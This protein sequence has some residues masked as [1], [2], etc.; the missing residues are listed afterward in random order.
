MGYQLY[1]EPKIDEKGNVENQ[2]AQYQPD[3]RTK[4]RLASLR[5]AFLVADKIRNYPFREFGYK[6]LEDKITELQDR[7]I[8]FVEP[9]D[10]SDP[11]VAWR[12]NTVRPLTRNK[13]LEVAAFITA[14]LMY[15]RVAATNKKNKES[16]AFSALMEDIMQW[17]NDLSDYEMQILFSVLGILVFPGAIMEEGYVEYERDFK[18]INEDGGYDIK[19]M[20]DEIYSGFQCETVPLEEIYIA[21]AYA[22]KN[23]Q[24]QPFVIRRRI[25]S[26]ADASIKYADNEN[27]KKYV[28]PGI[29]YFF[30]GVST[31]YETQENSIDETQVEEVIYYCRIADLELRIV[32]GVLM[33]DPDRPLQ[34]EDKLYPFAFSGYGLYDSGKFFYYKSM[35]DDLGPDQDAADRFINYLLD[36]TALQAMPSYALYGDDVIDRGVMV[37]GAIT[38]LNQG[39]TMQNISPQG[40]L[41]NVASVLGNIEMNA[42][43]S[44]KQN[45]TQKDMTAYQT[46]RIEEEIKVKLGL[47]GRFLASLVDQ[48]GNL[49][50]PT[51]VTYIT[52]PQVAEI[53]NPNTALEYAT[54]TV[55]KKDK[56][57]MDKIIQIDED[58]P[59]QPEDVTQ[60]ETEEINDKVMKM[61]LDLLVEGKEEGKEIIKVNPKAIRNL[62]YQ[63]RISPDTLFRKSEDAQ[64]A[65]AL[66]FYDRAM[67]HPQ[68]K[69]DSLLSLL[70]EQYEPG[71]EDKYIEKA[72]AM[73]QQGLPQGGQQGGTIMPEQN[74]GANEVIRALGAPPEVRKPK[75]AP[76]MII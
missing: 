65:F 25:N 28:R 67:L 24:K 21:D 10:D 49:R 62:K 56:S 47:F 43:S 54:I 53:S 26:Y 69:K 68:S 57:Q 52:M 61:S 32:N 64:R 3:D 23:I 58:V 2:I 14:N 16:K 8:N 37:P 31:V 38:P 40:N 20:V 35:V 34:R 59:Y 48:F 51:I 45:V 1:L 4:E 73:P 60:E 41:G 33:D 30:D 55:K 15:P 66:E 29:R 42:A 27:F 7:F 12:A 11:S 9:I 39:T 22:G 70:V 5:E 17:A 13:V 18:I 63:C 71:Q 76:E 50:L 74:K 36:G 72:M 6:S 46:S 19:K 75:G 44:S